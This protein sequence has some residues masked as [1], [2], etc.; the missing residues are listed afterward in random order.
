MITPEHKEQVLDDL[1][2]RLAIIASGVPMVELGEV[3]QELCLGFQASG[4]CSLLLQADAADLHRNLQR[5]GHAR[6]YFLRKSL[7]QQSQ[8]SVFVALSRTEALLDVIACG[9]WALAGEL[10]RWSPQAWLPDGEYESDFCYYAL[11]HAYLGRTGSAFDVQAALPWLSRFEQALGTYFDLRLPLCQRFFEPE[12]D[13]AAF[14]EAFEDFVEEQVRV[15]AAPVYDDASW[16]EPRRFV[17]VEGL[18]W[19]ALAASRGLVAP[20]LEYALCPSWARAPAASPQGADLLVQIE[21]QFG[22]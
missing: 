19:L 12:L 18:A 9:D 13:V 3:F 6:R 10:Q 21:Q 15:A 11:L 20:A 17:S 14:W 7:E 1:Q 8:D 22:L 4:I 2:E 5:S 16:I